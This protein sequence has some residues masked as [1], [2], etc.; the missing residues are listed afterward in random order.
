MT[1][2][3]GLD[4]RSLTMRE[5]KV[6]VESARVAATM[7]TGSSSS[8][9]MPP[10]LRAFF[11]AVLLCASLPALAWSNKFVALADA[12]FPANDSETLDPASTEKLIAL[13]HKMRAADV[14]VVIAIGF[15]DRSESSPQHLS[16]ARA[17]RVK[18]ELVRLGVL[19]SS[20]HVEGYGFAQ[21]AGPPE[22]L[23]RRVEIEVVGTY[24]RANSTIPRNE[25]LALPLS[26]RVTERRSEHDATTENIPHCR[27]VVREPPGSGDQIHADR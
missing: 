18:L 15:A 2:V 20:I 11:M 24:R 13:L 26:W 6:D 1:G 22:A 16:L 19:E 8:T 12:F 23:N 27:A 3:V 9:R 21:P 5:V 17:Q 4:N 10:T 25:V 7:R 14:E